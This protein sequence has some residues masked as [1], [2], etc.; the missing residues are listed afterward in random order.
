MVIGNRVYLYG[1]TNLYSGLLPEVGTEWPLE[2]FMKYKGLLGI[3]LADIS[4]PQEGSYN[5]SA[6]YGDYNIVV[7]DNL[8]RF[9]TIIGDVITAKTVTF[10]PQNYMYRIR[11]AKDVDIVA[12]GSSYRVYLFKIEADQLVYKA[13][14]T[15]GLSSKMDISKTGTHIWAMRTV[16]T[17]QLRIVN[18]TDFSFVS[19]EISDTYSQA[20]SWVRVSPIDPEFCV[21]GT[22]N[23]RLITWE[24]NGTA[25]VRTGYSTDYYGGMFEFTPD[26]QYVI[27]FPFDGMWKPQ[28]VIYKVVGRTLVKMR[29]I[30]NITGSS[31]IDTQYGLSVIQET[32]LTLMTF[33]ARYENSQKYKSVFIFEDGDLRELEF[34]DDS[35][36]SG[37]IPGDL[38]K[39][40]RG[41]N[42]YF[43]YIGYDN[44]SHTKR[45]DST[46]YTPDFTVINCMDVGE[47]HIFVGTDAGIRAFRRLD[48]NGSLFP[49]KAFSVVDIAVTGS[50]QNV[51]SLKLHA[52]SDIGYGQLQYGTDGVNGELNFVDLA[53]I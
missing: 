15:T 21:T 29:E 24:Y 44:V 12:V 26:G 35:R 9:Y 6:M 27:A 46:E 22:P 1:G 13:E 16:N 31:Y 11:I 52:G 7:E 3:E 28:A 30:E 20:N 40:G 32:P 45:V 19:K 53:G 23:Y 14:I 42:G 18:L 8:V 5:A 10:E 17:L 25:I 43:G 47:T 2:K 39:E 51:T 41:D 38:P 4:H 50:S 34:T 48:P 49:T 37:P 36:F 33:H